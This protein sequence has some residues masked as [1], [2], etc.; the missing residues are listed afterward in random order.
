MKI[1]KTLRLLVV[2]ALAV[3][4]FAL[5][6]RVTTHAA[7]STTTAADSTTTVS[8]QLTIPGGTEIQGLD[9]HDGT[10]VEDNGNILPIRY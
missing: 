3:G 9:L 8:P 10:I 2:L 6:Q 1:Q 5:L 4:A 7:S